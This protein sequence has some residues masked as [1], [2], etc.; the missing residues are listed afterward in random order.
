MCSRPGYLPD[1]PSTLRRLAA[2]VSGLMMLV[3]VLAESGFACAMPDMRSSVSAGPEARAMSGRAGM[4]EMAGMTEMAGMAGMADV[5]GMSDVASSG[6]IAPVQG[7]D[8][9]PCRFPWAPSG[10][11]DMA[12]CAPAALTVAAW[13]AAA[14]GRVHDVQRAPAVLAPPSFGAPPEPPPPRA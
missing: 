9:A 1:V 6:R 13:H 11:R 7:R 5:A 12:P 14:G 3:L 2:F 10:C 8:G 4:A